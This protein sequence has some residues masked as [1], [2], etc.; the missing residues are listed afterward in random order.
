VPEPEP[1]RAPETV[2]L[3]RVSSG[4]QERWTAAFS[5]AD[6]YGH[7]ATLDVRVG[8]APPFCGFRYDRPTDTFRMLSD[9]GTSWGDPVSGVSGMALE[10]SACSFLPW[11][12]SVW[13][14]GST[15]YFQL[16]VTLKQPIASNA[17]VWMAATDRAGASTGWVKK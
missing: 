4:S 9:D 5:D 15:M 3:Q 14:S 8:D 11:T 1:N 16:N 7:L 12:M 6:G 2:S 13:G 17:A 10:N